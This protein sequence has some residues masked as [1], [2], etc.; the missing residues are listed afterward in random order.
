MATA[1]AYVPPVPALDS[2]A[3]LLVNQDPELNIYSAAGGVGCHY[4]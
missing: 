3:H 4:S 2:C 1:H